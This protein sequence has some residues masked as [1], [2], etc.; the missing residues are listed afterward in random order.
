M[1]MYN[2]LHFS[3]KCHENTSKRIFFFL[4]SEETFVQYFM[5]VQHY[6]EQKKPSVG[7]QS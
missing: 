4:L 7:L 2:G 3:F 1:A 5:T 6:K